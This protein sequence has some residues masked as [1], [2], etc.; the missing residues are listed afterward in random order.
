MAF[1]FDRLRRCPRLKLTVPIDVEL[2]EEERR[3]ESNIC[4]I[5]EVETTR[6]NCKR[7][8]HKAIQ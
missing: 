5:I 2:I 7:D 6:D 8:A 3:V 4:R 1:Y